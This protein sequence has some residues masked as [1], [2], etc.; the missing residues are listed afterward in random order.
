MDEDQRDM[1]RK[2][3]IKK[4]V[5]EKVRWFGLFRVLFGDIPDDELPSPCKL[6][7]RATDTS[8]F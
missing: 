3:P 8:R 1:L 5:D 7:L 4:G 6:H 2:L